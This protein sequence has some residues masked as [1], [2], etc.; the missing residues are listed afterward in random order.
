MTRETKAGLLMILMLAGV[1]GFMVYKRLHQ[2]A[3]AMAQQGSPDDTMSDVEPD[4]PAVGDA[5]PSKD[6]PL[7]A[8]SQPAPAEKVAPPTT[9]PT[10]ISQ[11]SASKD[12][13]ANQQRSDDPFEEIVPEIAKAQSGPK[14]KLPT[15]ID[16]PFED[17]PARIKPV[18]S[19]SVDSNSARSISAPEVVAAPAG[20][21]F[22]PFGE[23]AQKPATAPANANRPAA[24]SEPDPFGPEDKLPGQASLNPP[25]RTVPVADEAAELPRSR[26][27]DPLSDPPSDAPSNASDAFETPVVVKPT[28]AGGFLNPSQAQTTVSDDPFA[29]DNQLEVQRPANNSKTSQLEPSQG[30]DT[31]VPKSSAPAAVLE[32]AIEDAFDSPP[33]RSNVPNLTIPSRDQMPKDASAPED[34]RFGGFR[35]ATPTARP[36]DSFANPSPAP[37][38]AAEN[39]PR[40]NVRPAP[41]SQ[42]DEDFGATA[43]NRPLIAGDTYQVEPSD[44]FWTISRKKYGTGRYFMALAQHNAQVIPDPKRMKPGVTIATPSARSLEQAYPQLIPKTAPADPI[45]TASA[46]TPAFTAQAP[47]AVPLPESAELDAGFFVANDGTPMYRVGREDTLSGIAQRHLG[48]SSRWVQVFELNRDVLTDGNTLKIGALLRLPAD[49]S[50]VDLVGGARPFR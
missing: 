30:F 41:V 22:D 35:P 50:R 19:D 39:P 14:P 20:G 7:M 45:Q 9:I 18:A 12:V 11:A 32:P 23:P 6:D 1:F 8:D 25:A 26:P 17:P 15:A 46:A 34:D 3:A 4:T 21:E 43:Q 49:A 33:P 5:S 13:P 27:D 29:S 47:A 44:N 31:N 48:R 40:R 16:D 10:R 36:A 24:L 28:P 2:P 37:A 42:I 38:M